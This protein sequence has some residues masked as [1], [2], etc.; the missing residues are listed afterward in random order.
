MR[1]LHDE[2]L[3]DAHAAAHDLALPDAIRA[4]AAEEVGAW[5]LAAWLRLPPLDGFE[6]QGAKLWRLGPEHPTAGSRLQICLTDA[7]DWWSWSGQGWSHEGSNECGGTSCEPPA[8]VRG[9][10]E[11][12]L[13]AR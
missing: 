3:A 11:Q 6:A 4:D 9:A 8:S 12:A 7:S 5:E 10:V 13:A 2:R 1:P